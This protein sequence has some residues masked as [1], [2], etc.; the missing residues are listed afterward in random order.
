M[1]VHHL[2]RG[3]SL[4]VEDGGGNH[5]ISLSGNACLDKYLVAYLDKGTVPH[6]T[7]DIDAVCPK[8][9]DPTPAKTKSASVETA[10]RRCT[11]CSAPAAERPLRPVGG[12]VTPW[13]TMDP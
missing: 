1:T 8:L 4:V 12:A 3:S 5:G 9:P 11:V 13:S 10:A 7:G 6:G 2:L